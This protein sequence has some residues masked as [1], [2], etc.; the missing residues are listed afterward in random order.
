[1]KTQPWKHRPFPAVDRGT[2][3]ANDPYDEDD[4]QRGE[5][6]PVFFRSSPWKQPVTWDPNADS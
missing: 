6:P 5:W 1:M 3:E 4:Q 2:C